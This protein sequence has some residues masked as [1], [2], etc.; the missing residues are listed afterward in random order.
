MK[1]RDLKRDYIN[2][3]EIRLSSPCNYSNYVPFNGLD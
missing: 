3:Y 2:F 1:K